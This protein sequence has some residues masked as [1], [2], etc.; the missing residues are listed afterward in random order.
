MR[1]HRICLLGGTGF[2]GRHLVTHLARQGH[3]LRILTRRRE[4]HRNLLVVPTLELVETNI[5]Y[6]SDLST[7]FKDCDAVI[8][9]VGVLNDG[10]APEESLEAMH[11]D[12]PR[13][14]TEACRFNGITRLLHMSALNADPKGP[15]A[16]LRSKGTGENLVHEAAREGMQVTSF[17][18]SVIF[19]QDD[20]FFNRFARLLALTPVLPLACP[21]AR[22]APVYV[23][24]VVSALVRAL[25]DKR[26]FGQRYELCGP[27]SHTLL[28]LVS[29]TARAAGL[30]RV[31]MGLGDGASRLQ[32]RVME[33]APG[34]PFTRDNYL[35][36]QVD[37]VC[38]SDGLKALGITPTSIDAVVPAYLGRQS[39]ARYFSGLRVFARRG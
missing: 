17:R 6:V 34:K 8:N 4:R 23:G 15:S 39:K 29:Y 38:R 24:D 37:S 22:F 28:D 21:D 18:P 32:A 5:H 14:V 35:S 9:L 7:H 13:K 33:W 26:T 36:M 1:K 20:D 16:Y 25:D 27:E 12:L 19:G 30:W 10:K 3:F 2:V 31:I 11:A